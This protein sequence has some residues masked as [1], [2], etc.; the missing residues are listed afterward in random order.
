MINCFRGGWKQ[1][2]IVFALMISFGMIMGEVL[3]EY[4]S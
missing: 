4:T 3:M 1:Q 2:D